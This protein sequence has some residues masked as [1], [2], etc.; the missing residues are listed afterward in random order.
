MKSP[1]RNLEF[2]QG[3]EDHW[4]QKRGRDAMLRSKAIWFYYLQYI[5]SV[6]KKFMNINLHCQSS[7]N[8]WSSDISAN[9]R[10][11][12]MGFEYLNFYVM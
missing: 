6:D 5:A 10:L 9:K 8:S 3:V 2:F 11:R 7:G 1:W 4:A 12:E